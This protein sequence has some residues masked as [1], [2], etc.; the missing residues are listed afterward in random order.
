MK[1]NFLD[2]SALSS[3]QLNRIKSQ[4]TAIIEGHH[5]YIGLID[6]DLELRHLIT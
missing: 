6:Y 5:F 2:V 1:I 4:E 3:S